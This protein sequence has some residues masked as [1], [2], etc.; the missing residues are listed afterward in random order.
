M[1]DNLDQ[2]VF[3]IILDGAF[4]Y[5]F[6]KTNELN[7]GIL[8]NVENLHMFEKDYWESVGRNLPIP[9]YNGMLFWERLLV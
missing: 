6:G 5:S 4:V 3:E 2:W 7:K 9:E 1:Y 8:K